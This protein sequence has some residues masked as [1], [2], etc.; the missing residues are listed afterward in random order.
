MNSPSF[1]TLFESATGF[2]PYPFQ[3]RWAAEDGLPA[4]VSVPTGL[5]KTAGAVLA[6][7]WRRRFSPPEV[8]QATPRRL[9]Y[10][11][12]MR[13]LVEQTFTSVRD[14]LHKLGLLEEQGGAGV[15][16]YMLL[17]GA[18]DREW[19]RFPENDVI[20]IGTQDQLLSRALNRGYAMSRF[21]WPMQFGLLNVDVHWVLDEVQLM[22]S[23]LGT[24][25]Q[26]Q[27]FRRLLGTTCPASSTWMSAT[28]MPGWLDT[29][30]FIAEEDGPTMLALTAADWGF[31]E[32][33]Q[34]FEASKPITQSSLI[35]SKDGRA[36]ANLILGQHKAG[37]LTLVVVNTVKRAVNVWAALTNKKPDAD[38]VLVHSR[39][40]PDDR[41]AAL[42][43]L[44][45]D[46]G[47][48]G[49][50]AISTQVVE[51]GVDV[52]ATTLVTDLAPWSS[53]VQRF[54]R[55]NRYGSDNDAAVLWIDV[56]RKKTAAAPYELEELDRA[57]DKLDG[58]KDGAPS[59]LPSV[60]ACTSPAHVIRRRDLID[61][62]DATPDLAGADIDVS[63][64]IRENDD[65]HVQVFWREI[66]DEPSPQEPGPGTQELCPV[67]IGDLSKLKQMPKWRWD[68]LEKTWTRLRWSSDLYPGLMV[69]LRASDGCYCP[70][71]GWTGKKK[72]GPEPMR[73][74][75]EEQ[76]HNDGDPYAETSWQT[77]AEHTE[78]VV[79]EMRRLLHAFPG[80]SADCCEALMIAARWHDAGKAH[81]VFQKAMLGDPPENDDVLTWAKTGRRGIHY[82]RRGFRHEL[83]SALAMI[84]HGKSDLAAYLAAAHHGKVR[85]SMRSLPY[86][87]GDPTNPHRRFA[88]G[89][90]DKDTLHESVLGEGVVLPESE[91][92]LSLME[93]G[94]GLAGPSWMARILA[95]RDAP[96]LGP[97]RLAFLETLLRVADWRASA[98]NEVDHV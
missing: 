64:F 71:A 22:G 84:A 37:T 57:A 82:E 54:G 39:F 92:D 83:A 16:V 30:D 13:V 59:G 69:M 65:R 93:V 97:F 53:M 26:L 3:E 36:E 9:V 75:V 21:R 8:R 32:V 56:E 91:M 1:K 45:A 27:A 29:V 95:L 43:R 58:L 5:G 49:L 88:R 4:L 72:D 66:E 18:I 10:C 74:A 70:D 40:R 51:A 61:L 62:F 41:R 77:L 2:K 24:T 35:A 20:I 44:L 38:L 94:D 17:G 50:I 12:P 19:D 60:D 76:D 73:A 7:L 63:R 33:Q 25:T 48:H 15:G 81:P 6:W 80:L 68:H 90:W 87:A 96:E 47:E 55:C 28:M 79:G 46:P 67:P 98:G 23:G 78:V 34:R 14:W 52:S 85:L 11:L 42:D 31:P 86:E 89:I